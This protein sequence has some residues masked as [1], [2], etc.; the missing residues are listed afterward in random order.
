M[1]FR[2]TLIKQQ[3]VLLDKYLAKDKAYL[4]ALTPYKALANAPHMLKQM[5]QVAFQTGIGPMSAVA[6]AFAAFV[7][8][9]LKKRFSLSE[10]LVENGGDIYADILSPIDIAVFAGTS[11]LSQRIGL[12]ITPN[13]SPVGICTSAGTVGPSLSF[14]TADAVMIVCQDT[15]LAD[16]YA[17]RFANAIHT[18]EDI[19]KVMDMIGQIP[20]ILGAIIVKDDKMAVSGHFQLKLWR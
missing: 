1:R 19:P 2:S 3:R 7:G 5:E 12:S 9:E 14:G 20:E 16:S 6:G 17:T 11:P 15:L 10:I 8:S 13:Y 4:S 18:T